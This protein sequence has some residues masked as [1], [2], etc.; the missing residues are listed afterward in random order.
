MGCRVG[1]LEK[2]WPG[3]GGGGASLSLP[4]GNHSIQISRQ[5]DMG[6]LAASLGPRG[7][8]CQSSTLVVSC[9]SP[10]VVVACCSHRGLGS[11]V[12]WPGGRLPSFLPWG[13]EPATSLKDH[14]LWLAGSATRKLG[15]KV[16]RWTVG[17]GWAEGAGKGSQTLV[18]SE[19]APGSLWPQQP[20]GCPFSPP[21]G[22][23]WPHLLC[24]GACGVTDHSLFLEALCCSCTPML[25][26][27]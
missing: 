7:S 22:S 23:W 4:S 8:C 1:R 11:Q 24:P 2:G 14:H 3:R 21:R 18:P 10:A 9:T 27:F 5:T 12:A 26:Y 16:G 17:P 25:L 13:S 15:G 19:S 6:S 20:T